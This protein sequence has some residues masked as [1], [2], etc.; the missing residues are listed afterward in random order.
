MYPILALLGVELLLPCGLLLTLR[1][2]LLPALVTP[3]T[4][5]MMLAWLLPPTFLLR[6]R[7]LIPSRL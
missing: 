3:S 6:T 2:F 1:Q 4:L 7:V 5:L